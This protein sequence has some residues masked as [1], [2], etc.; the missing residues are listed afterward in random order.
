MS[1]DTVFQK[2]KEQKISRKLRRKI[3]K[4]E[5]MINV[6]LLMDEYKKLISGKEY[7]RKLFN[8]IEKEYVHHINKDKVSEK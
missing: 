4:N 3:Q 6:Y 7:D 5:P 1:L 2:L 8:K